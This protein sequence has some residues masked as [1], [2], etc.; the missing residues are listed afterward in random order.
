MIV[1]PESGSD[2]KF[3]FN[4]NYLNYIS[5]RISQPY[6]YIVLKNFIADSAG[7]PDLQVPSPAGLQFV[8]FW[9]AIATRIVDLHAEITKVFE[10]QNVAVTL[11]SC[12]ETALQRQYNLT[13]N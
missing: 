9:I 12:I 13:S 11:Y 7:R 5:T 3:I 10:P 8:R 1:R 2:Q 6:M 4:F